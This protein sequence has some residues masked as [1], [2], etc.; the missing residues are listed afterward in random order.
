MTVYTIFKRCLYSTHE[1][2]NRLSYIA[3]LV[4]IAA[5][6]TCICM[7]KLIPGLLLNRKVHGKLGLRSLPTQLHT[8]LICAC[9]SG[10]LHRRP[11]ACSFLVVVLILIKVV[12]CT[13]CN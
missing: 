11:F 12:I 4:Q 10:L 3:S 7:G 9:C 1:S 2:L 13:Y 8:G 6:C 5:T